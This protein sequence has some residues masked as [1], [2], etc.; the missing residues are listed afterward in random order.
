MTDLWILTD[1]AI[2]VRVLD[3]IE[4]LVPGSAV[5]TIG[6]ANTFTLDI[7]FSLGERRGRGGGGGE[8]GEEREGRGRRRGG[9]GMGGR[10]GEGG[11]KRRGEGRGDSLIF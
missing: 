6:R 5:A 8:G 1:R 3:S 4:P 9:E 11:E 7:T 2:G 10:G